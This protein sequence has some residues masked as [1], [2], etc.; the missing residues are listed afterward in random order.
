MNEEEL[1]FLIDSIKACNEKYIDVNVEVK[2]GITTTNS[3][4]SFGEPNFLKH[5]P[6]YITV[7]ISFTTPRR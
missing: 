5:P 6:Q 7:Y 3:H 4:V 1:N 2:Q